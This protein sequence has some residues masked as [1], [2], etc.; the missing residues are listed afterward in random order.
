MNNSDLITVLNKG[1]KGKQHNEGLTVHELCDLMDLNE[2]NVRIRIRRGIAEGTVK[3]NG[4]KDGLNIA[5]KKCSVPCY[6]IVSPS[7]PK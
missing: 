2:C 1:N 7:K 3:F 4:Y 6:T 5:G